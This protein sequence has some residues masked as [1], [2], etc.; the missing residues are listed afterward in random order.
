[1]K[2]VP[3]EQEVRRFFQTAYYTTLTYDSETGNTK[4]GNDRTQMIYP[5]EELD[6]GSIPE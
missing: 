3:T 1:M 6:D 5:D 2:K 4:V